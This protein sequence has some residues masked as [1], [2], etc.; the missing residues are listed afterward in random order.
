MMSYSPTISV[1][2]PFYH[3]WGR[4]GMCL[5]ALEQQSVP[6]SEFEIIT[7]NNDPSDPIPEDF[8]L[9]ENAT[10]LSETRKGSYAARNLALEHTKGSI[11]AFTD[12]DCLP[13]TK[14]LEE[15]WKELS[16]HTQV[17][18]I[19]GDIQVYKMPTGDTSA[20]LFEKHYA[21]KQQ[22][23]VERYGKSVTANLIVR[24]KVFDDVGLFDDSA[25]SGEDHRWTS[26]AVSKGY[27]MVYSPVVQVLHPARVSMAELIA[28]RKRTIGGYYSLHYRSLS[29]G[30]K[31]KT[32]IIAAL[33][34][35]KTAFS[36]QNAS[37]IEKMR[38]L[39]IKWRIEW[40]AFWELLNLS[41]KGK[42]Q[43][44]T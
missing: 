42:E 31:I 8:V 33:A 27:R 2:I 43:L 3:D 15:A 17:D 14:W 10:L 29:F 16:S 13:D 35:I 28:K 21:F 32:H 4:L 30:S 18:L 6:K 36:L 20:Y 11:I 12:S 39:F 19:G 26:M 22:M 23:N 41:R 34:P 37:A 40:S 38:L 24:K 25:F 1:V 5:D 7:V 9:P 44:R